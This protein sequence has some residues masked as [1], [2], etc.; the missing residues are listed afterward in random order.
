VIDVHDRSPAER[1]VSSA[2]KSCAALAA[3]WPCEPVAEQILLADEALSALSK[4]CS[5]AE[6]REARG[7]GQLQR[8]RPVRDGAQIGEAV[9]GEHVAEA[10]A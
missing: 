6:H 1:L 2:M 10:L 9:V 8:L 4:P 5:E 7:A 3:V